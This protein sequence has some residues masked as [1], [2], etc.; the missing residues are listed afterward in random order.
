MKNGNLSKISVVVSLNSILSFQ[1][2][3]FIEEFKQTEDKIGCLIKYGLQ[4]YPAGSINVLA[5]LREHFKEEYDCLLSE[6]ES[7]S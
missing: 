2:Q 5:L 6:A 1:A 3:A 4:P 7:V